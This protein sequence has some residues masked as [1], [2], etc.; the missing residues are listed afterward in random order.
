MSDLL[1]I[2]EQLS[3]ARTHLQRAEWLVRCPFDILDRYDFTIRNRLQL[4]GFHAGLEY[5]ERVRT[6]KRGTRDG[7]GLFSDSQNDV[8]RAAAAALWNAATPAAAPDHS[9]TDI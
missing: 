7:E 4:A 2:I 6:A 8:L 1:P 9:V 5:L 3:D